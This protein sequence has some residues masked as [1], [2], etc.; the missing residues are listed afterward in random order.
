MRHLLLAILL[1]LLLLLLLLRL[2]LLLLLLRLLLAATAEGVPLLRHRLRART[3]APPVEKVFHRVLLIR[4]CD[5]IHGLLRV[6]CDEVGE[7][8]EHCGRER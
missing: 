7:G 8:G 4:R 1:L 3:G 5:L 6:T 2:L